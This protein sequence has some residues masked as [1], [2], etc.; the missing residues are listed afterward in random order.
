MLVEW[1][2]GDDIAIG[3]HW[4]LIAGHNSLV[5]LRL[6]LEEPTLDLGLHAS[7]EDI[8]AMPRLHREGGRDTIAPRTER[9]WKDEN[10]R[11]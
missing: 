7:T 2:E 6:R 10:R 11:S 5:R 1:H 9:R 3:Q 4:H 8:G